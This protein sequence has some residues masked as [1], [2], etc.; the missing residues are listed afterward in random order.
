MVDGIKQLMDFK[1]KYDGTIDDAARGLTA[2]IDG[3]LKFYD[4]QYQY[5]I[6][7]SLAKMI[8]DKARNFKFDD[9]ESK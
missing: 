6:L 5:D 8:N 2:L 9:K 3:S 4:Q 1:K 7:R